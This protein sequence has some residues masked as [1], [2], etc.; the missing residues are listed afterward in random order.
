MM[1]GSPLSAFAIAMAA[2]AWVRLW[3]VIDSFACGRILWTVNRLVWL[4]VPA[5]LAVYMAT[6]APVVGLIDSGELA[7][8]CHLLNILHPTGY[9]LYTV[10]GRL[11]SII[12][13]GSVVN[14]MAGLS[15]LLGAVGVGLLLLFLRRMRIGVAAAGGTAVM[16][17]FSLPVWAVSVD[18]EVYALTLVLAVLV[19][20]AVERAGDNRMVLLFAYLA[21]FALTNHMSVASVVAGA[22][23]AVLLS[24]RRFVWKRLPVLLLLFALGVSPYLFLML[25]ARAGPL[26]AWGN[27]VSLERL[28]WHVTGKQYQVWMF[29]LPFSE[30]M[31]NA[32]K[33]I[34]LLARSFVWVFVP[35]VFYGAWRLLKQRRNL[36][37][38]LAVTAL[39]SFGYAVNYSIPDIEAYYLPCILALA[40]FCAVGLDGIARRVGRWRYVIWVAGV[41]ALVLNFSVASRRDQYVAHDEALNTLASAEA[42]ATILT[43]WW[44]VYSPV[45][46]FRHVAGLRSDVCIIDKELLRRS[47]YFEYLANDYPWLI[48]NSRAELDRYLEYLD[49][50]EHG[51]LRDPAGIQRA[52]IALIESFV[53]NNPDRPAYATFAGNENQDARQM[54]GGR[55]WV[56]VGLLF[57]LR[58]D[59]VVPAFDYSVLTVRVPARPDERTRVNLARYG[60]FARERIV[61]LEA[62]GRVDEAG[63][64]RQWLQVMR[65]LVP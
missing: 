35:V 41:A 26:L 21:G 23:V 9:P 56:P 31:A 52:F 55:N 22:G 30:V 27:P 42:N 17:A 2:R 46:Y 64:V 11:A 18:V 48:E 13:V 45:F 38:G 19:W 49:R 16:L 40:V 28:W 39:L 59:T 32:G 58:A 61:N 62:R 44:D 63:A 60:R 15:A 43:D 50:F 53:R 54:F 6:L 34:A 37:I 51:V 4:L 47:W 10:I 7:A 33:G 8:G 20:L 12:P 65:R 36:A 3:R 25:R 1:A 14:R 29:S 24:R 5:V 57:Q